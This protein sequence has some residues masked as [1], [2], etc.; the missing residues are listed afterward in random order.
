MSPNTDQQ[1]TE[2]LFTSLLVQAAQSFVQGG[3]GGGG[4]RRCVP[5]REAMRSRSYEAA[6]WW[7]GR[8]AADHVDVGAGGCLIEDAERKVCSANGG[9]V[10]PARHRVGDGEF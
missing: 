1:L 5:Q 7:A 3:D 8:A 2:V 9:P 4:L 6:G 10:S